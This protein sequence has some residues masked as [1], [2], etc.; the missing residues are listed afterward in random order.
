MSLYYYHICSRDKAGHEMWDSDAL[1]GQRW[2]V[3]ISYFQC[4]SGLLFFLQHSDSHHAPSI[5]L[6]LTAQ[7]AALFPALRLA[8]Q[9]PDLGMAPS[10]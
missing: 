7:C 4:V 3:R 8:S 1:S 2:V 10:G 5:S 9:S 6:P